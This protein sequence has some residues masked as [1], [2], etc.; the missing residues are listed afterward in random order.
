MVHRF[1]L[2]NSSGQICPDLDD[3]AGVVRYLSALC[4]PPAPPPPPAQPPAGGGN[5]PEVEGG[6]LAPKKRRRGTAVALRDDLS[7]GSC[8]V[9]VARLG[10]DDGTPLALNRVLG[11]DGDG[12]PPPP[13]EPGLFRV[14]GDTCARKLRGAQLNNP[15]SVAVRGR[16]LGSQ[17]LDGVLGTRW[18]VGDDVNVHEDPRVGLGT[19]VVGGPGAV[20]ALSYDAERRCALLKV[21]T[22]D[23]YNQRAQR[24]LALLDLEY[25]ALPSVPS[26]PATPSPP[27]LPLGANRE[28]S[29]PARA[30]GTR[31]K[32]CRC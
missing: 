7:R 17:H 26:A 8:V 19:A 15:N 13:G 32:H 6:A 22:G 9:C 28:V 16:L 11:I 23:G 24:E 1:F 20:T 3:A 2:T 25:T 14:C 21:K 12:L 10:D 31:G 27:A 18:R 30:R 29:K 5:L 4:E